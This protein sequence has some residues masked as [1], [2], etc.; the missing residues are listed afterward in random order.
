MKYDSSGNEIWAKY[1]FASWYYIGIDTSGSIYCGGITLGQG[2]DYCVL[3]YD[4]S[5]N[6][7]LTRVYDNGNTTNN[8]DN[9]RGNVC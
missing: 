6:I 4:S 3:K 2:I 5:G 9:S 1:Y 8:N 7:I